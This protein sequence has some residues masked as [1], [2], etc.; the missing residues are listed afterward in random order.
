MQLERHKIS[1][2]G[3]NE[4]SMMFV[5]WFM[6]AFLLYT[7]VQFEDLYSYSFVY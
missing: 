6:P 4:F 1:F 2:A 7:L 3:L 5:S